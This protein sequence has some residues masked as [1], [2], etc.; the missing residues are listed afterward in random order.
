M[1][2]REMF[3]LAI[4]LR[5]KYQALEIQKYGQEWQVNDL[6]TGFVGDVGDLAKLIQA[7]VGKRKIIGHQEKLEHELVDC[8]WSIL[9][10]A[11]KCQIDLEEVFPR[12]MQKLNNQ[13][14]R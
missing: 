10:I 13:I 11:D 3:Q 9:V 7:E 12:E 6:L 1:Q 2:F 14:T 4:E 8:L 5:K